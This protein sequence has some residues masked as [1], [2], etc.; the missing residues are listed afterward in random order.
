MSLFRYVL[1]VGIYVILLLMFIYSFG[2]GQN[3]SLAYT[4]HLI[5]DLSSLL[6]NLQ[7]LTYHFAKKKVV[8]RDFDYLITITPPIEYYYTLQTV[9]VFF[10]FFF[11][12][13]N[14]FARTS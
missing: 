11:F 6:R 13:Y 5:H 12:F 14:Q 9:K 8:L 2:I 4:A 10:F 3:F 7:A 1:E